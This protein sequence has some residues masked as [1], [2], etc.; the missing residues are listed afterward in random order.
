M[1]LRVRHADDS[2]LFCGDASARVAGRVAAKCTV[3]KVAHHGAKDALNDALLDAADP[4]AA[5]FSVGYNTYG[6]PR[7]EGLAL[8]DARGVAA[9]RTDRCGAITC[10]FRDGALQVETYRASED[11]NDLE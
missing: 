11:G 8:L 10:R 2:L 7:R 9:Y 4:D 3:L 6:H 1:I 5:I